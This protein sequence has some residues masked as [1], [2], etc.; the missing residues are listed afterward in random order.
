V[1]SLR[2]MKAT[3]KIKNRHN[4]TSYITCEENPITIENLP[5]EKIGYRKVSEIPFNDHIKDLEVALNKADESYAI[6]DQSSRKKPKYVS[7]KPVCEL[8]NN[9]M[10]YYQVNVEAFKDIKE[11]R[12]V[13]PFRGIRVV[14]QYLMTAGMTE[15]ETAEM[16]INLCEFIKKNNLYKG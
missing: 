1:I 3:S 13:I 14:G 5:I 9:M 10:F 16:M 2:T 7:V 12:H 15:D 8:Y 4:I 6:V 11:A